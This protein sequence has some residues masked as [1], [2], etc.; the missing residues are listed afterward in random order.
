MYGFLGLNGAGKSTTIKMLTGLLASCVGAFFSFC[1]S[2]TKPRATD[3][4][5]QSPPKRHQHNLAENPATEWYPISCASRILDGKGDKRGEV[6]K[7]QPA[8]MA[9]VVA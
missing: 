6:D 2:G 9:K 4:H 8:D 3:S 7:I 1:F 5:H